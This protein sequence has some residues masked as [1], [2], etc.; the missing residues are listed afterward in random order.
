MASD[1]PRQVAQG[2]NEAASSVSARAPIAGRSLNS[3]LGAAVAAVLI[4]AVKANTLTGESASYV[5]TMHGDMAFLGGML[6]LGVTAGLFKRRILRAALVLLLFTANLLFATDAYVI[7]L[8]HQRLT[9]NYVLKFLPELRVVTAL[10]TPLLVLGLIALALLH[11]WNCRISRK[12]AALAAFLAVAALTEGCRFRQ[13]NPIVSERYAFP[14]IQSAGAFPSGP[15]SGPYFTDTEVDSF[16]KMYRFPADLAKENRNIIMISVEH[17]SVVDSG[18]AGGFNSRLKKLDKISEDGMI[19]CNYFANYALS[20]GGTIALLSAE[21]PIPFPRS[22]R[23]LF[24]SFSHQDSAVRRLKEHGY[25]AEVILSAARNFQ[26]WDEYFEGIGF[27]VIIAEGDPEFRDVP[28]RAMNWVNDGD[29]YNQVLRRQELASA[30]GEPF[31]ILADTS[32]SHSPWIDPRSQREGEEYVWDYV[33]T[34]LSD[35]YDQLKKRGFFEN[36]LLI[37][38][39]DHRKA[40]FPTAEEERRYGASA[41]WR[42]LLVVVGKG[43]PRGV[44]DRRFL[45]QCDLLPNLLKMADLDASL[46]PNPVGVEVFTRSVSDFD[47]MGK[48]TVFDEMEGGRKSYAAHVYAA[49][50]SWDGEKPHRAE[51]IERSIQIQRAVHQDNLW[52]AT[53]SSTWRF[54]D[55][56]DHPDVGTN[57]V[58]LRTFE[59]GKAAKPLSVSPDRYGQSRIVNSIRLDPS[60]SNDLTLG[61]ATVLEFIA[62]L[63]VPEEGIY[64]FQVSP[65]EGVCLAIDRQ[66][67][68]SDKRLSFGWDN[69]KIYLTRGPHR[70]DLRFLRITGATSVLLEWKPPGAKDFT[71]IPRERFNPPQIRSQQS[72]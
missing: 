7:G 50:F 1:Q 24:A 43:I 37:L 36:G 45:Q 33:D 22:T 69:D 58:L 59:A 53:M 61:N 5:Q 15:A 29:L 41:A 51:V 63:N 6:F 26:R 40:D 8:M 38:T 68:V 57:G 52:Q 30:A 56:L 23:S 19:F 46:S 4:A 65:H 13:A 35:L 25:H 14:R 10:L 31:F 17:L 20:E 3:A 11:V 64:W 12:G 47:N 71:L 54:D 39:G 9:L 60:D 18:R 67:V 34:C 44:I 70:I 48:L 27:D 16:R 55:A 42:T 2:G 62:F 49:Q 72:K 32:S 28:R 66:F 21:L